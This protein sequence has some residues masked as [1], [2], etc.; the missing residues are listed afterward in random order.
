MKKHPS[1]LVAGTLILTITGLLSRLLGFAYRIYLSR[2]IGAEAL[3]LYQMIS[4][5]SG[6]CFALC[7]GPIQTAISRFSAQEG[8]RCQQTGARR[9]FLAGLH[10]S[11]ALAFSSALIL[12]HEADFC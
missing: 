3:G 7:C 12:F 9:A 8:A 2:A 6:I 1:P 5:V 11:E 10:L 4:P